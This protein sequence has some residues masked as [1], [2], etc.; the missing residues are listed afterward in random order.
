MAEAALKTILR[1]RKIR[2]YTVS[3]AGLSATDGAPMSA[4]SRAV[5][6]EVGIPV[7]A[8]FR[9]RRLNGKMIKDAYAVVCMT[10]EQARSLSGENVTSM[11]ALAGTD[12]PDPYGGSMERYRGTL[13]AILGC[14]PDVMRGLGINEENSE[15]Q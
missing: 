9:A 2:W 8:D 10:E 6:E 13:D 12:I 14:L 5:L 15:N 1:K 3:S 7:P 4:Y 11:R